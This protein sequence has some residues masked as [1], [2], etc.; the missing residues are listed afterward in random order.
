MSVRPSV[1]NNSASTAKIFM[2]MIF[3][4][5]VQKR[6]I[7]LKSDM[8]NG[9]PHM[10][11]Y[12]CFSCSPPDLNFL[13]LYIYV[14]FTSYLCT[15]IITTATGWQPICSQIYIQGVQLKSGPILIEVIFLLRFTS[16]YITQLNWIYLN[17][18]ILQYPWC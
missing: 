3:R 9:V 18:N 17:L 14:I 4:K 5:S 7:S 10:H 6:Q 8:K 11:T 15:C 16:C 12:I 1:W 2:K 13:D